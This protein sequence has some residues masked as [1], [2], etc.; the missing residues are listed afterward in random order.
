MT[1]HTLVATAY[2]LVST[3]LT[4]WFVILC[5]LYVSQEQMVLSTAIAGGKWGLQIMLALVL[6]KDDWQRFVRAIGFVCLIG[7]VVLVPYIVSA[8]PG[9]SDAPEFFFGSLILAI[10][11]MI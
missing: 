9:W 1:K 5:P 10:I 4:W 11:A 2:F 8:F 7:S 6:L 3:V